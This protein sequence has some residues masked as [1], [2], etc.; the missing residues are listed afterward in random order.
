MVDL[1]WLAGF[2]EAEGCFQINRRNRGTSYGCE[3]AI[4]LRDDD[5]R[6]LRELAS[7]LALGR[8]RPVRPRGTSK[9]QMLWSINR[10]TDCEMLVE[11]LDNHPLYGRK[12]AQYDIWRKAV[13]LRS[14]GEEW[15][16]QLQVQALRAALSEAKRFAATP[17]PRV[18]SAP[19]WGYITGLIEGDG[20]LG[21]S[22]RQARLSIHLRAD[23]LPLLEVLRDATGF[24]SISRS[25]AYG[26]SKP[27]ATWIVSRPPEL[28]E[29]GAGMRATGIRGRKAREFSPWLQAVHELCAARCEARPPDALLLARCQSRVLRA[30][31]YST[32]NPDLSATAN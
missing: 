31:R 16:N 23:D 14:R 21:L 8:L 32:P 24:G 11:V 10:W 25:D 19:S 29:I 27:S 15:K 18:A 30:R 3:L 26:C 2:I 22:R 17:S 1:D 28:A 5:Q 6:L 9:P 4:Q 12:R 20:H 7:E 13:A